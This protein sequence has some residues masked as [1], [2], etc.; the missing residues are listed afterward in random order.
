MTKI[1]FNAKRNRV[2]E[3]L[4]LVHFD[5]CESM[6]TQA[7]GGYEYFITFIDD[8]LRYGFVYLMHHKSKAF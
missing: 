5:V 1:A 6:N 8:Y 3:L 4:E 2:I 7:R